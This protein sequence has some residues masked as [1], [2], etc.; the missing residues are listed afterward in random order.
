MFKLTRKSFYILL[1]SI[2]WLITAFSS[3]FHAVEFFELSNVTWMGIILAMAFEIGQASVLMSILTSS[4]VYLIEELELNSGYIGIIFAFLGIVSAITAKKQDK[5]QE[6]FK[7]KTLTV[8]AL[9][10]SISIIASTTGYIFKLPLVITLIIT[11]ICYSIKYAANGI[12]QVLILKYLSNFANESIDSK[13][14]SIQLLSVSI[15]NAI[16]GIAASYLFDYI[17]SYYAMLILGLTFLVLFIISLIYM[18]NKLGLKPEEYSKNETQY[19]KQAE[20]VA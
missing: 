7:N 6:R 12:Y 19:A 14:Y 10:I 5:F 16:L 18:K 11:I 1:F 17:E 20:K 8:L 2:L 9:A 15:C 13:I 4:Q 3:F